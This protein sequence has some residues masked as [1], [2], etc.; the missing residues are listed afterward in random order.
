MLRVRVML[1]AASAVF[2]LGAC[3]TMKA[4]GGLF[5]ANPFQSNPAEQKLASG[6]K[7][8]EEGDYKSSQVALQGALNMG[9][10]G[11]GDQ[12]VAYKYLAFIDCVSGREKQCR[13]EF[14]KAMEIDPSFDLKPA[15]AGHPI[16]GPVFRS[17]K[18]KSTK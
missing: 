14:K 17:V 10:T 8:Y 18:D 4:D 5:K 15:E 3:E 12:T 13:D 7:S 11:K 16:W 1:V 6:I 2:L 9:L